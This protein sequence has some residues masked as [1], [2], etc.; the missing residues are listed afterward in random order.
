MEGREEEEEEGEVVVVVVEEEE[1]EEEEED[2]VVVV[3]EE[4]EVVEEEE[5]LVEAREA[6]VVQFDLSCS[7]FV[8]IPKEFINPLL[9]HKAV[10]YL[11]H[12]PVE[13]PQSFSS[14]F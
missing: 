10:V 14:V 1:E 13:I 2:V 9:S 3:E 11:K 7:T 4:V 12:V 5:V 6:P 8:P